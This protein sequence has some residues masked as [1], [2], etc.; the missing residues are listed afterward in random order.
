[1]DCCEFDSTTE[2]IA[3]LGEGVAESIAITWVCWRGIY[4]SA[5][6]PLFLCVPVNRY[7]TDAVAKNN[8]P[9]IFSLIVQ[10]S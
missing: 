1:M 6:S 4:F 9:Q 5:Y 7:I 8:V 2:G 3:D 10:V